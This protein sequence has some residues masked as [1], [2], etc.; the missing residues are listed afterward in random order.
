[1]ANRED[2]DQTSLCVQGK[3]LNFS[4]LPSIENFSGLNLKGKNLLWRQ[5]L[6]FNSRHTAKILKFGTPQ[7]IAIIVPKIEKLM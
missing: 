4:F 7:T 6:S 5:T 1:M 2:P 3:N